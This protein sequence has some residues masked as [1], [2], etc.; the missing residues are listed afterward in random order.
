MA[1]EAPELV[2]ALVVIVS[3]PEVDHLNAALI[4]KS[5]HRI[6]PLSKAA[7]WHGDF[8]DKWKV[9]GDGLAAWSAL[10]AAGR[11]G[12]PLRVIYVGGCTTSPKHK[13]RERSIIE[14]QVRYSADQK[15][16]CSIAPR[17]GRL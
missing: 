15:Q 8:H 4:V 3:M 12:R 13:H 10:E 9:A 16:T 1:S 2:I 17:L 5:V 7:R 11:G 14:D 6:Q